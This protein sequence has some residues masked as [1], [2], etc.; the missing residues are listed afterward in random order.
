VVPMLDG[1]TVA[2]HHGFVGF[3]RQGEWGVGIVVL[4]LYLDWLAG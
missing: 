2:R 4:W 1:G 3:A